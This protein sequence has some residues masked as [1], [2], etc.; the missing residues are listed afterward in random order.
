MSKSILFAFERFGDFKIISS[1]REDM[2][3][4]TLYDVIGKRGA[5]RLV[6]DIYG[7]S[8]YSLK[9]KDRVLY[10]FGWD[11][12]RP[13]SFGLLVS[14]P[15]VANNI[16]SD[17][18]YRKFSS[19]EK[20]SAVLSFEEMMGFFTLIAE[21]SCETIEYNENDLGVGFADDFVKVADALHV[22]CAI[23]LS[24]VRADIGK[25]IYAR[26]IESYVSTG[27]EYRFD[28]I[29]VQKYSAFKRDILHMLDCDSVCF[30]KNESIY[31]VR[32]VFRTDDPSLIG[33]K[34]SLPPLVTEDT[35]LVPDD[36]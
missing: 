34:Y 10:V 31:A 26:R 2:A 32:S 12:E 23:L 18:V 29:D 35:D 11:V 3:Y 4:L 15:L 30:M 28:R 8:A 13:V 5:H 7:R 9:L 21:A 33:L 14:D 6:A 20:A 17:K 1:V 19:V 36:E 16:S 25:R 22:F 27:I 24:Y